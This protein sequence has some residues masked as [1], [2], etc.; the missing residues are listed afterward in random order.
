M[1]HRTRLQRM[2]FFAALALGVWLAGGR[3]A[4]AYT[5]ATI[6]IQDGKAGSMVDWANGYIL[7][8]VNN[9][10]G[11]I[12]ATCF[13]PKAAAPS[14]LVCAYGTDDLGFGLG[15]APAPTHGITAL[16]TFVGNAGTADCDTAPVCSGPNGVPG[17]R[18]ADIQVNYI[19]LPFGTSRALGT[20][21]TNSGPLAVDL[22]G[23]GAEGDRRGLLA[24]MVG[25]LAAAGLVLGRRRGRGALAGLGVTLLV[26]GGLAFAAS[27]AGVWVSTG[28]D[29]VGP[30]D[31]VVSGGLLDVGS[32]LT[33]GSSLGLGSNDGQWTVTGL[34]VT[35]V[36]GPSTMGAGK[37]M[38]SAKHHRS[39]DLGYRS[40]ILA[41]VS[42]GSMVLK[43]RQS[44]KRLPWSG[45]GADL[46][47]QDVAGT[48]E[49]LTESSNNG[50]AIGGTEGI[51]QLSGR[52]S[53]GR[54]L[55]LSATYT[56]TGNGMQQLGNVVVQIK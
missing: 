9:T 30:G 37:V 54:D 48:W 50:Q 42:G 25:V 14:S 12:A 36:S 26:G 20:H 49:T 41:Q 17:S 29:G 10:A 16:V 21:Q 32:G 43:G 34:T 33:V 39:L 3:P 51:L 47:V 27:Q 31:Q 15:A 18:P 5:G 4:A 40:R 53:D 6:N 7:V 24:L 8:L 2:L 23:F 45:D 28:I 19:E 56:Q 46:T 13:H 38:L 22:L 11:T 44:N 52:T 35:A 55:N 1:Q